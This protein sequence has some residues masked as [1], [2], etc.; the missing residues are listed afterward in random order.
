MYVAQIINCR[1]NTLS[2]Y[3]TNVL[4]EQ[5]HFSV[6]L[7]FGIL[8]HAPTRQSTPGGV[9]KILKHRLDGCLLVSF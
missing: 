5:T 9:G 7:S 1:I 6:N 8:F 2:Q 4:G 3:L